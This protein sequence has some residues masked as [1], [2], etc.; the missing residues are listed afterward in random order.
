MAA[1]AKFLFETDFA[2]GETP[3]M[4][5]VE[6]ERRS[7]DAEAVA[8]RNGFGAGQA[9]ARTEIEQQI[10]NTLGVVGDTLERLSR[11]LYGVEARLEIEAVE[12]AV[13][14]ARKLAPELVARQP[15]T[16]I[17]ALATECFQHLA[18]TP[19]ISVRVNDTIFDA[20][21]AKLDDIAQARGFA[22]RL[23]VMSDAA[24]AAGDCRIEWADGGVNRDRAATEAAIAEAVER[25]VTA[26]AADVE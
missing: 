8:Y 25:Y 4:T 20:A 10:A 7:A 18:S 2:K 9:Q 12:V 19:H 22:G 16:E 6:H 21:K 14:V 5:V 13:A 11:G 3:T 23:M 1:A 26:R 17:T 15:L 24:V